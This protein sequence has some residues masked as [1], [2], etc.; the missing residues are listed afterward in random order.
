MT[1]LYP[2]SDGQRLARLGRRPNRRDARQ[3]D[4][5]TPMDKGAHFHRCDFQVHTP[6]DTNWHGARPTTRE[7][8]AEYGDRLVASCRQK[9]IDAIAVTDHHDFEYF[10]VIR[11]AALREKDPAGNAL[12]PDQRLIVFP[13]L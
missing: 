3:A 7:Q 1:R 11:E 2:Y 12:H 13:G 6:R 10:P 4:A 8:R 9:R 5:D